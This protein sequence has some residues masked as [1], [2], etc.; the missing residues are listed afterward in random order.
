MSV[1]TDDECLLYNFAK[2][3]KSVNNLLC[4]HVSPM[5]KNSKRAAYFLK[6]ERK[7]TSLRL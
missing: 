2:E 1:A 4:I 7:Y 6:N 5:L 3:L